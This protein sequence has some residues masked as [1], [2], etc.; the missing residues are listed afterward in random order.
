M[1]TIT[2]KTIKPGELGYVECKTCLFDAS[3]AK[4]HD[5]GECEYCKL[6]LKL[7][8]EAH[9]PWGNV[10]EHI[11]ADGKGRKY[12]ALIGLSGGEDSSVLAYLCARVWGLRVLAVHF[13]NHWNTAEANNN[14]DVLVKNLNFDFIRYY[15]DK[16]EYDE[17]NDS[18]LWAGVSDA[19]ITND[20]AMTYFMDQACKQYKIKYLLNG[21]DVRNEG[22][23]PKQWSR[24][25]AQYLE[26]VY[27]AYSG[28]GFISYPKY[29]IWQQVTFG[30]RGHK[31]LRPYHHERIDRTEILKA[32]KEMGWKSYGAKHMENHYTAMVGAFLLPSKFGINKARTY[33]SAQIREG[34]LTKEEAREFL[35]VTTDF[36]L[37][38]LGD[39]KDRILRLINESPI[40]N[41]EQFGGY[42][43]KKWRFVIWLLAKFKVVPTAFYQKYCL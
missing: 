23:S 2:L 12:D 18:L 38:V 14:I 10:L 36:D 33:L 4:I 27:K 13:D 3:I 31:Q 19:D 34:R 7:T 30:L 11:K 29:T 6:Q 28:H 9:E 42:N 16:K 15:I 43:F 37:S 22:N 24:I 32:L 21:H 25:D 20:C 39:A 41:R 1:K 35:K 26:N 5:D 17:I 40:R 8:S